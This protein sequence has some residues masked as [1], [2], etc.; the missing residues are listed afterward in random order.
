MGR[1]YIGGVGGGSSFFKQSNN[2]GDYTT[3][4]IVVDSGT[5]EFT[6]PKGTYIGVG[7]ITE[8]FLNIAGVKKGITRDEVE[9]FAK[10]VIKRYPERKARFT[11]EY[12]QSLLEEDEPVVLRDVRR[13]PQELLHK[14]RRNYTNW[15]KDNESKTNFGYTDP[16]T[17]IK[18]TYTRADKDVL[19]ATDEQLN[20]YI[21][22]QSFVR[23]DKNVITPE[24]GEATASYDYFPEYITP[25]P[26]KNI[27]KIEP[28]R[29]DK[30]DI[31]QKPVELQKAIEIDTPELPPSRADLFFERLETAKVYE[32][33]PDEFS[34]KAAKN[35]RGRKKVTTQYV[36]SDD[37]PFKPDGRYFMGGV[38]A[39]GRRKTSG[40]LNKAREWERKFGLGIQKDIVGY[41]PSLEFGG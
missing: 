11:E 33:R 38:D 9:D 16:K 35:V 17:F 41:I 12:K 15:Y 30:I 8:D 4:D 28:K 34:D 22:N 5:Y 36:F 10:A 37:N 18:D 7:A 6:V 14:L 13:N 1:R 29:I 27:E 21:E 23:G 24:S 26:G 20:E 32:N 31:E 39:K 19:T 2:P 25:I 40:N 3:E